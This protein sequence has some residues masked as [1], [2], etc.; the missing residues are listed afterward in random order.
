MFRSALLLACILSACSGSD[1]PSIDY[2]APGPYPVGNTTLTIT[3]Q[4]R[5]RAL[6]VELWYPAV[7]S[8]RPLADTGHPVP[9]FVADSAQRQ[10][11]QDLLS[12][13]PTGCPSAQTSSARDVELALAPAPDDPLSD[14]R[15]DGWPLLLFSHCHECV[16]FSSFAIAEHLASHGFI[17][18]APDHTGNTLFDG[19]AGTGVDLGEEFLQVRAED[20]SF[21]ASFI[22][23]A[24]PAPDAG[25]LPDG[26]PSSI[27]R[28]RIG[29]LG[30]S[31][32][33]VTTGLVTQDDARV[34][35]GLALASPM[36]NAF[37][38]GVR[39]NNIDKPVGFLVAVEDN[40][41]TEIGNR[42]MR[43]N[44]AAANPPAWKGEVADAGHWSFSDV[45]GLHEPFM[46]GCGAGARQTDLSEFEYLP[47]DAGSA[48]ASSY[49]AAFFAAYLYDRSDARG[50][51]EGPSDWPQ[52][53]T[54]LRAAP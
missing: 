31:F 54:E 11:Y 12:S 21:V 37:L 6:T 1:A 28:D 43:D 33:A 30:H 17:V 27:D 47:A 13:A 38:P 25:A 4:A 48:I 19:L 23:D 41:I 45:A 50:F 8:A 39:M 51:L 36:E 52:V 7:D 20:I 3:D 15:T 32:G 35:A 5:G 46:P 49:A 53:T 16:R 44:F 14:L 10:Q 34:R 18:A 42:F 40:S 26:L 9:E 22:L 29:M 24:E 2:A